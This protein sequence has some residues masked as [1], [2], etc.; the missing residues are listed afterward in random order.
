MKLEHWRQ[1]YGLGLRDREGHG[2]RG[3]GPR[4]TGIHKTGVRRILIR[5]HQKNHGVRADTIQ[6]VDFSQNT[7][8]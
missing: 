8:L 1:P 6:V 7:G 3:R 4:I 2:F 5:G